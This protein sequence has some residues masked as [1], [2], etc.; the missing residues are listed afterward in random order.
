MPTEDRFDAIKKNIVDI[1]KNLFDTTQ[2]IIFSPENKKIIEKYKEDFFVELDAFRKEA[3]IKMNEWKQKGFEKKDEAEADLQDLY[4]RRV[5][6]LE[7]ARKK[8]VKLFTETRED[9]MNMIEEGKVIANEIFDQAKAQ[10]EII[11]KD[12]KLKLSKKE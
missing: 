7:Q 3:E 11:Y 6:L 12:A 9:G 8:G 10:L 2:E 1:H 4:N 5:E